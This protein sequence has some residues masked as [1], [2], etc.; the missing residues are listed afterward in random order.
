MGKDGPIGPAGPPGP[1]GPPFANPLPYTQI[2]TPQY[3]LTPNDF[4]VAFDTKTI[5][6]P[7]T[8]NLPALAD[9][10][11]GTTNVIFDETAA[12]DVNPITV[13]P[14]P[15]DPINGQAAPVVI[16]TRGGSIKL[17]RT[18]IGWVTW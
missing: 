8:A 4:F 1:I 7:S 6:G 18:L 10:K 16:N 3:L 9:T 13:Q 14:A 15:G 2:S 17:L 11:N 12:A 5:G